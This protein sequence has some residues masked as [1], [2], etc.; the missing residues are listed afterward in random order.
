MHTSHEVCE[1]IVNIM[2]VCPKILVVL[3]YYAYITPKVV[4]WCGVD[5]L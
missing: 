5:D 3:F 4:Q 2:K 1:I